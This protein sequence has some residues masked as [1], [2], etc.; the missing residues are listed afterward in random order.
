MFLQILTSKS[1][2]I[3]KNKN[4][5]LNNFNKNL[6]IEFIYDSKSIK[7]SANLVPVISYYKKILP[8]DLKKNNNI[9]VIHESDLPKGR[10]MSPL[11]N[12]ILKGKKKI[13][14][15]VFKCNKNLDDGPF[16]YKKTFNYPKN[17]VYEE[18]KELQMKNSLFLIKKLFQLVRQKK[19]KLKKQIGKP[20]F[21]KS[22]SNKINELNINRSI[23]SQID[24][25]RTRDKKNF[26]AY[27]VYNKRKFYLSIIPEKKIK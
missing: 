9:F 3:G 20:S 16:V 21:F 14:T 18:I 24:I 22:I 7:K 17:L 26:R 4:I 10:G 13:I 8:N 6:K 27:F 5:I 15:T 1:S 25:I 12:Q 23:K 11:F 2:F 19:F